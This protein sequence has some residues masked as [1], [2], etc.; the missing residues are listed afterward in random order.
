MA[1]NSSVFPATIPTKERNQYDEK[2]S[3]MRG[4]TARFNFLSKPEK[5]TFLSCFIGCHCIY[6]SFLEFGIIMQSLIALLK[7][8]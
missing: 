1:V 4:W 3:L 7:G 2:Y 5:S 8:I 6:P